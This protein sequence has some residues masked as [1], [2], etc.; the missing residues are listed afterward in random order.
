MSNVT[1]SKS[2]DSKEQTAREAMSKVDARLALSDAKEATRQRY[3]PKKSSSGKGNSIDTASI[4][5]DP[6]AMKDA[7]VPNQI[8][9]IV[10]AYYDLCDALDLDYGKPV[11]VIE[12]QNSISSDVWKFKQ[13]VTV[14]LSHYRLMIEGVNP[15]KPKQDATIHAIGKVS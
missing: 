2:V 1:K 15:W 13:D 4:S 10:D 3:L 14:V 11:K 8:F 12:L 7:I 9:I 6:K 5:F